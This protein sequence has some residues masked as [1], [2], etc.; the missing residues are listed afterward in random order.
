MVDR[1]SE[2]IPG[3]VGLAQFAYDCN[4][5]A[6]VRERVCVF[7]DE[8]VDDVPSSDSKRQ[9]LRDPEAGSE[10]F[11]SPISEPD[12]RHD[13]SLKGRVSADGHDRGTVEAEDMKRIR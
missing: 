12:N 5:T 10:R 9:I 11:D 7:L 4:V 1:C 3:A 6:S 8:P 13:R 2:I